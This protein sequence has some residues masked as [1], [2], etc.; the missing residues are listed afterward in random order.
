MLRHENMVLRRQITRVRYTAADRLW[1]AALARGIPRR[2]W[3]EVFA[4][5]PAT[6]LA[7]HRRLVARTWH[8]RDR[9]RPGRRPTPAPTKTLIVRM[10]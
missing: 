2:R 1:L 8:Y 4:V 10:A 6:V 7:W 5:T 3:R 9:R